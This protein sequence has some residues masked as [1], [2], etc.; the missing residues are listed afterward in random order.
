MHYLPPV[1]QATKHALVRRCLF[2]GGSDGM[3]KEEIYMKV[4]RELTRTQVQTA[5][6][7]LRKEGKIEFA[8]RGS[9]LQSARWRLVSEPAAP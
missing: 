1:D 8:T 6:T 3:T 4:R 5:L 7:Q 2:M 9:S